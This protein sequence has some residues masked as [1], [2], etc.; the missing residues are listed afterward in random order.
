MPFRDARETLSPARVPPLVGR[1]RPAHDRPGVLTRGAPGEEDGR[2]SAPVPPCAGRARRLTAGCAARA[3]PRRRT[4]VGAL[5]S[6]AGI[7]PA[8]PSATWR[9]SGAVARNM[10][11]SVGKWPR[12]SHITRSR[13][14]AVS[15]PVRRPRRG[16]ASCSE[17]R[18]EGPG[19]SGRTRRDATSGNGSRGCGV[20]LS[21]ARIVGN[22]DPGSGIERC[23][24]RSTADGRGGNSVLLPGGD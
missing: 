14:C 4:G 8:L 9:C 13:T 22:E 7:R 11:T 16:Q 23:R 12:E 10:S 2:C 1:H 20:S 24:S 3:R 15:R 18:R 21:G 17:P 19:I 6:A 5:P